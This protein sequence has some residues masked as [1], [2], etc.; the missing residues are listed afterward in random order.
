M[1]P[2]TALRVPV[3][4]GGLSP[5][6]EAQHRRGRRRCRHS[7]PDQLQ[8][9]GAGR[10]LSRPAPADRGNPRPL[11]PTDRRHAGHA[12]RRSAP[13]ATSAGAELQGSPPTQKPLALY[14][15]IVTV[16]AD[17]TADGRFRHSGIRRHRAGDGGRVEHRRNVGRAI[18]DVI[19]PRSRGADGDAAALPA[20]R[21]QGHHAA[22]ISTTS[23]ARPA[24]TPSPSGAT[25]PVQGHRQ[26]PPQLSSSRAKQ[27]SLDV[28]GA[29]C[30]R[31]RHREPR[32]QR[33]GTG[34]ASTLARHY[35]LD[36][37]AGDADPDA[38]HGAHRWPRARA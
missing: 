16:A 11:R 4:L 24:T 9:A 29:R 18:G 34:R 37:K 15:G 30:R 32:R 3:K 14:S 20:Q 33:H 26:V 25:G 6:E 35:A 12:R 27:R 36:V 38:P 19:D 2:G 1:R 7:Q 10:L 5:G 31:R 13:A 23:R 8:A 21:R 22:S 28:A 17:G